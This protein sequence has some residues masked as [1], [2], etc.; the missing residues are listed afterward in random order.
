MWCLMQQWTQPKCYSTVAA[1]HYHLH[2][3]LQIAPI[4][5]CSSTMLRVINVCMYVCK[6]VCSFAHTSSTLQLQYVVHESLPD[7]QVHLF[8]EYGVGTCMSMQ[9]SAEWRKAPHLVSGS[10][11]LL[12]SDSLMP[13]SSSRTLIFLR[14]HQFSSFH[15]FT[16]LI[17]HNF[18]IP[19]SKPTSF[20]NPSHHRSS[21]FLL[22]WHNGLW[23]LT[24]FCI[25]GFVLVP[26]GRLSWL[27]PAFDRTLI[28]HSYLLTYC[29]C[30]KLWR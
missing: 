13:V 10:N 20:R 17:I 19:S 28:S 11:S 25:S 4:R 16:T 6:Y 2:L 18:F 9:Q 12:L 22:D 27:L 8:V 15:K 1:T 29:C 23:L 21:L 3:A 5:A 14:I 26:C 30:A 7:R 24:I